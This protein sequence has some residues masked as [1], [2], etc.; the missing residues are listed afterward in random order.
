MKWVKALY[1]S[2]KH[3]FLYELMWVNL[4]SLSKV[5]LITHVQPD[6]NMKQKW[7]SFMKNK[8]YQAVKFLIAGSGYKGAHF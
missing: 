1:C 5:N 3:G 7:Y 2:I 8:W 6:G 4:S